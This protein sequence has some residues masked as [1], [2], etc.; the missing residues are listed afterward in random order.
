MSVKEAAKRIG[1]S[2]S[3]CYQLVAERRIPHRRVGGKGRRGRIVIEEEDIR[4]FMES[5]RREA[6]AG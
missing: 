5:C 6:V 4:A 1:I 2:R 3:L